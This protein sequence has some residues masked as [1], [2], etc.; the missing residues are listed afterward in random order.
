MVDR[1][2]AGDALFSVTSPCV[3][4]AFPLDLV[5]FLGNCVGA[6]A[7]ETVCNREPVDP[8]LLQKFITSLLK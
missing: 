1:T 7:V 4:R 2:G 6:L 3:Y 8:V 5:G